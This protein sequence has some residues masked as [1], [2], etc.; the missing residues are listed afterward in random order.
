MSLTVGAIWE[1]KIVLRAADRLSVGKNKDLPRDEAV[2]Q[3][4]G[5]RWPL[6]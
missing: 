4:S 1:R 2:A 6:T 3:R 5:Q